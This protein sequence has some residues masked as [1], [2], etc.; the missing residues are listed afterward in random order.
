MDFTDASCLRC[1]LR[2]SSTAL[3]AVGPSLSRCKATGLQA[4]QKELPDNET[5][6]PGG[7]V[8]PQPAQ[9]T[10]P[11]MTPGGTSGGGAA[12]PCGCHAAMPSRQTSVCEVITPCC[13][14]R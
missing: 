2:I 14:R 11:G 9:T 10:P 5:T 4:A 6:S 3:E 8:R 1:S 12:P 7:K 13:T